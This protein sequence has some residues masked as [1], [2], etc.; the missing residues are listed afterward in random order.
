MKMAILSEDDQHLHLLAKFHYAVA[1]LAAVSACFPLLNMVIGFI[2][3]INPEVLS[4]RFTPF[5]LESL[6][7]LLFAVM[8]GA[9]TVIGWALAVCLYKTARYLNERRRWTFCFATAVAA[10]TFLPFGTI[11][12]IFTI[13]VLW[14]PAV[15][16]MFGHP[17]PPV[18]P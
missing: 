14:R 11:L 3:L 12:G 7:G 18:A 15:K 2:L 4:A 5:G 16:A 6:I 8:G 10:C 9:A 17:L 1:A 13:I